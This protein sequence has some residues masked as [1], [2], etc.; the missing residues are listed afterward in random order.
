MHLSQVLQFW[1][2]CKY[3]I[4]SCLSRFLSTAHYYSFLLS[5]LLQK[6]SGNGL[7]SAN[8]T[9]SD[10][11]FHLQSLQRMISGCADGNFLIL[12]LTSVSTFIGSVYDGSSHVTS[13]A[14]CLLIKSILIR[15]LYSQIHHGYHFLMCLLLPCPQNHCLVLI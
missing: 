13:I 3:G 15:A 12:S 7:T 14:A 8:L 6:S 11:C 9:H 4:I 10:P 5:A 1:N 2:A